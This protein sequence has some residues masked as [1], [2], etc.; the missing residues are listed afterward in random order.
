MRELNKHKDYRGRVFK[1]YI[2]ESG[3]ATYN[4]NTNNDIQTKEYEPERYLCLT[5]VVI[6][7]EH[8]NK[9][10]VPHWNAL[11]QPFNS[12]DAGN[13][14]V[15]FHYNDVTNKK[16]AFKKL[17]NPQNGQIKGFGIKFIA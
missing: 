9:F 17:T 3:Q 7:I 12:S 2:D 15:I 8:N 11:K 1:M 10:I 5:G 13:P 14:P 16:R 6:N 4:P